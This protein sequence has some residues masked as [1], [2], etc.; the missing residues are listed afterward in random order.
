MRTCLVISV[1]MICT[2]FTTVIQ[3][4]ELE[5]RYIEVQFS[6]QIQTSITPSSG[7]TDGGEEIT[8]RG[9]GFSEL[10][11]VNN[12][13]DGIQHQWAESVADYGYQAGHENA[14]VVDS[15]GHIHIVHANGDNYEFKH[16][17]FD[18]TSWISTNIK[19]CEG[20]YCWDTHM[21]IDD[22]DELHA[23]YSTNNNKVMYMNYDGLSWS[24]HQISSTANVGPVGIAVDSNNYPHISYVASG[25]HC[26]NGLVLASYDGT[27]WSTQVVESGSNRGCNSAIIINEND[28]INIAF[29]NRDQSKL[30]F[31]TDQSGSWQNYAVDGA[32]NPSSMYP[33][34]FSSMA[35]DQ[36]GRFHIAHYDDKNDNLRY[37]TGIP[38]GQWI[39][40]L[41]DSNGNTGRNPSIAIDVAGNPHIVYQT[42][43]GFNLKYA[44]LDSDIMEPDWKVSTIASGGD[45][46]DSNSLFIDQNGVMHVAFSDET[47]DIMKYITKSTGLIQTKEIRVQFGQ[48][49]S[50]T[51]TVVNDTTILV[52]TPTA[53]QT[54]GTIELTLWDK[55][56]NSHL[57]SSSFTFISQ[58]DLDSDGVLND[59]DDCPNDAGTSTQDL[60]GCPDDDNDGYSN[61]GDTF[62]NNTNEWLDSD[63]DGVGDNSDIFPEDV[64]E[65][66]DSDGDGV[67]E[68]KDV[69]PDTPFGESVNSNQ[70][71]GNV[72]CSDSQ[73]DTDGDG[74]NDDI[75]QCPNEDPG[76]FDTGDD[77]CLDDTDGDGL[78][79]FFDECPST[80][81]QEPTGCPLDT[82]SIN[83]NLTCS[84][85]IIVVNSSLSTNQRVTTM[86]CLLFNPTIYEGFFAIQVTSSG[87]AYAAPG[88]FTL[89]A[90]SSVTFEVTILGEQGQTGT[91]TVTISTS[92]STIN[93]VPCSFC[94]TQQSTV[95]IDFGEEEIEPTNS[96][97]STDSDG[98]GV[99]DENDLCPNT[100]WDVLVDLEGCSITNQEEIIETEEDGNF[101]NKLLSGEPA[102]IASTVGV[103]AILIALIGFL[104]S[105][106]IAA[107]LPE[108]LRGL[109]FLKR[110]TK[111]N[112]EERR[113]LIHLQSVVQAYSSETKLLDDE[114]RV[115]AADVNARYTNKELKK[116]TRE[117]L[118][119]LIRDL[120]N[121]ESRELSEIA[122]NDSYF[123]LLGTIDTKQRSQKLQEDLAMRS[124]DSR[125][126]KV[127]DKEQ[128]LFNN[129]NKHIPGVNMRGVIN[130]KD[131]HEYIEWPVSSGRWYIRNKDT[132]E[133]YEWKG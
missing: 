77:G 57:L 8:I 24:W 80:P 23:A 72:G 63:G 29:Q 96:T 67:G 82:S 75:D 17:I 131:G 129:L 70:F 5:E 127:I 35:M 59:I 18:G 45:M 32:S 101:A 88:Q 58:D 65:W 51:G 107:M 64:S 48:Y 3:T 79:D 10:A 52:T 74:L 104:Q 100:P 19:T 133:W 89:G 132:N 53:G 22:N 4:S 43:N 66:L 6:S 9:S 81:S 84:P 106:M 93:G 14:I 11:F 73:I 60:T 34:Y 13:S 37:S 20:L 94:P 90:N 122:F 117:L 114:L 44:T 78:I 115:L 36:D 99:I 123:G 41:V 112:S 105:N 26:G 39:T 71:L 21:V 16:S 27:D 124:V 92:L 38:N 7:W 87:L 49:G 50:V 126:E 40:T 130:Q 31:A 69:C 111:L 120:R 33:G 103:S 85:S 2:V 55:D 98:D 68:N 12:T 121:M 15:N 61:S 28:H 56:D 76:G 54:A 116:N 91:R 113:E 109:Q 25:Q 42:W 46:G 97:N 125:F 110:K 128:K 95:I 108:T 118:M 83:Y 1:L 47:N 30:I 86:E 62:P 102:A 119:T